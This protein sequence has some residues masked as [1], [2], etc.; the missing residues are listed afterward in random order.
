MPATDPAHVDT[1]FA[2]AFNAGDIEPFLAL[3]EPDAP[4]LTHTGEI[5]AD[6]GSRRA[7]VEGFFSMNP[8]IDL[9]TERII[10]NGD[11]ALVY[12]PWTV[13]GVAPDGTAVEMAGD[14]VAVLRRQVDGTWRFAID[15]PGWKVS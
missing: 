3:Y 9:T 8:K 11:L 14:S 4:L 2:E 6:P 10:Q 5:I 12:S 13:S 15:N 7:Y 1:L